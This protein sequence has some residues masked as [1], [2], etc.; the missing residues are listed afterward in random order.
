MRGCC[1][2]ALSML[3]VRDT[4]YILLVS[5]LEGAEFLRDLVFEGNQLFEGGQSFQRGNFLTG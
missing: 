2:E 3:N 5:F 4:G 1:D